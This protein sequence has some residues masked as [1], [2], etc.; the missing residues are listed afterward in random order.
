M[1]SITLCVLAIPAAFFFPHVLPMVI[2][3]YMV[4]G[5][6][7]ISALTIFRKGIPNAGFAYFFQFLFT[8]IYFAFL[9]ILGYLHIK[10]RWKGN[11]I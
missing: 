11:K 1:L 10:P 7:T 6:D 5:M 2:A 3:V 9:T 4:I 8:P